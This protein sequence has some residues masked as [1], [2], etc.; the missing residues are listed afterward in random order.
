M[1]NNKTNF[2]IGTKMIKAEKM[3]RGDYNKFKGWKIP[4]NENPLDEGYK[5]QYSDDYTSWSPK[6]V[7][8]SAYKKLNIGKS[9]LELK[10]L[11]NDLITRD[12]TFIQYDNSVFNAPHNYIIESSCNDGTILAG[13]HFQEGPL[14]ENELNGIFM[15][16]LIA[17]CINRLDHFQNSE[18]K[19][20]YNENAKRCLQDSLEWL[21][22]RTNE[23][24][25]RNILGTNK[26]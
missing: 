10:T 26:V 17:I 6:E 21:R 23:R 5:V 3:N 18:Y 13:I 25:E 16:D 1:D 9:T 12:Y 11:K 7:F 2:Y 14:K 24:K 20:D 8:E 19:C 22:K 4:E 15:E